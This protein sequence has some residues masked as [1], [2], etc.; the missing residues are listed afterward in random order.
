MLKTLTL[1]VR[2]LMFDLSGAAAIEYV[3]IVFF[4]GITGAAG[5]NLLGGD[6]GAIFGDVAHEIN[7]DGAGGGAAGGGAAGGGA[8]GGGAAGGGAAGGGAG[9]SAGTG[10]SAGIGGSGGAGGSGGC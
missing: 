7:K 5:F 3:M 8:A 10:G 9:G 2:K 4:I 6:L 1:D